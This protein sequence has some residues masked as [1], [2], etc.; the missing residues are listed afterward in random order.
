MPRRLTELLQVITRN[1]RMEE[2]QPSTS[3]AFMKVATHGLI[4]NV[5]YN[6]LTSEGYHYLPWCDENGVSFWTGLQVFIIK[7]GIELGTIMSDND[8]TTFSLY[9]ANSIEAVEL[10]NANDPQLLPKISKFFGKRKK[11]RLSW[12]ARRGVTDSKKLIPCLDGGTYTPELE[13]ARQAVKQ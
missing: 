12:A 1:A 10:V 6:H 4:E 13:Y 9:G 2:S 11:Q 5:L 7:D 8:L 3:G